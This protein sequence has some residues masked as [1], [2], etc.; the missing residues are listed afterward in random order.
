MSTVFSNPLKFRLKDAARDGQ[1]DARSAVHCL[2]VSPGSPRVAVVHEAKLRLSCRRSAIRG[3][4]WR[5]RVT[6]GGT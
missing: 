1:R 2:R 5:E 6:H 3:K 4:V